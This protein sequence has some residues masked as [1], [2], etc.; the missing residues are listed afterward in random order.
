MRRTALIGD[1][2]VLL[3][4]I[5]MLSFIVVRLVV[6]VLMM[7][8]SRHRLCIG[9]RINDARHN[10]RKLGEQEESHKPRYDPS[11]RA[12]SLHSKPGFTW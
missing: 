4:G 5:L 7:L 3:V 11:H 10:T 6:H 8:V 2:S 12:K 1:M 9:V